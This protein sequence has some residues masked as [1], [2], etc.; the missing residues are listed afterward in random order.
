[1]EHTGTW[2]QRECGSSDRIKSGIIKH[3]LWHGLETHLLSGSNYAVLFYS[4]LFS[5]HSNGI[6]MYVCMCVQNDNNDKRR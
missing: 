5:K 4:L 1:M 3:N 6:T 2:E